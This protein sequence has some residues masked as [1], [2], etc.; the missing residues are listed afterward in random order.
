V[1]E[2][3]NTPIALRAGPPRSL[4]LC[5]RWHPVFA[6]EGNMCTLDVRGRSKGKGRGRGRGLRVPFAPRPLMPIICNLDVC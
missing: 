3:L 2:E 5:I 6:L 1:R 4:G